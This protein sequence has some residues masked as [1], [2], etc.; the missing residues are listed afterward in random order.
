M[1]N[2]EVYFSCACFFSRSTHGVS[3][4]FGLGIWNGYL[5]SMLE[6]KSTR[7]RCEDNIK[8]D[9]ALG[10]CGLDSCAS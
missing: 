2:G 3:V 1:C 5:R 4:K 8:M 6:E 7:R 10:V 9:T